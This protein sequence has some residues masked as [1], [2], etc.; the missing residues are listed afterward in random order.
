MLRA[1]EFGVCRFLGAYLFNYFVIGT[2]DL[3]CF[4]D[5]EEADIMFLTILQ[6][7]CGSR[8]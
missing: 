8:L 4:K 2:L 3:S 7:M 6:G 1:P 5:V